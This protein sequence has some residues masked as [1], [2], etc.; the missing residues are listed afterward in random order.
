MCVCACVRKTCARTQS[1][2]KTKHAITSVCVIPN[3]RFKFNT[4]S[5]RSVLVRSLSQG[6]FRE[7]KLVALKRSA[8]DHTLR[9]TVT[10]IYSNFLTLT[11]HANVA[12]YPFYSLKKRI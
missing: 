9:A 8:R 1:V 11:A 7:K 6:C 10:Q 12:K 3:D 4:V 5:F 2:E